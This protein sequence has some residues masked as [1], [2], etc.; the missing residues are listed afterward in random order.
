MK[1]HL[2]FPEL[3]RSKGGIQVFSRFFLSA[4]VDAMPEAQP[5]LFCKNDR[6]EMLSGTLPRGVRATCAGQWPGHAR[7]VA[8]VAQI[9]PAALRERP[10]LII[11]GHLNFA[12]A[13][14]WIHR[15][16]GIPFWV[17]AHGIEAW[18]LHRPSQRRAVSASERILAVSRFTRDRLL[19]QLGLPPE[20]V[21]LL[22]NTFDDSGLKPG[23]KPGY[24][25]ARYGLSPLQPV[26]LTVA[27]LS[28]P[29]RYK[30]YDKIIDAMPRILDAVPNAHYLLVG[31]GDDRRRVEARVRAL[32]LEDHVSLA[33]FVPERELQDHYNLCDVFAMPS[34]GEGFGIVFLEALACG[35]PVLAGNQD[36]SRD[37]L[38]DGELGVL[39]DPD[40]V[41]GIADALAAILLRKQPHR[42]ICDPQAL[43]EAVVSRYGFGRFEALLKEQLRDLDGR[44]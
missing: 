12:P 17:I 43:R 10:D 20:R 9:V 21:A 44:A 5:R 16:L 37:A 32:G 30:G 31:K 22:P 8:F 36:G 11:C 23:P 25:L 33:G 14:H 24:L 3:V 2:W 38:C 7:T 13:A 29:E 19:A 41:P 1:V 39:I 28:S 26:I 18:D 42:L 27:R 35:K 4:L 15:W 6:S 40:D 34:K